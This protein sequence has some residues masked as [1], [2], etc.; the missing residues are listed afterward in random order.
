[1]KYCSFSV[2]ALA[3]WLISYSLLK[4]TAWLVV[5]SDPGV[6]VVGCWGSGG[7]CGH[8]GNDVMEVCMAPHI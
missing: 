3:C 4:K 2:V 8:C 6:N 1:M 5:Q 7:G